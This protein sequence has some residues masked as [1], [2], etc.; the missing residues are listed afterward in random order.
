MTFGFNICIQERD[1]VNL[2]C[3]YNSLTSRFSSK[4]LQYFSENHALGRL[5]EHWIQCQRAQT[6]M[7]ECG[8]FPWFLSL[9][10]SGSFDIPN[11]SGGYLYQLWAIQEVEEMFPIN[12]DGVLSGPEHVRFLYRI[13]LRDINNIPN[14]GDPEWI[15]FGFCY[16]TKTAQKQLLAK[17]Y[18][19]LA[20]HASLNEIAT[21][22]KSDTLL[23]LMTS[24][25]ISI[26]SLV[27]EGIF[28]R[29][30]S[31]E[32]IGI[33]RLMSEVSH[34]LAGCPSCACKNTRCSFYSKNEPFLCKE[35]EADYGFLSVNTWERW[36]LL[37]FYSGLFA[38]P[39]FNPHKMQEAKRDPDSQV[40]ETYIESLAPGFRRTIWDEHLTD[41]M[42]PKLGTRLRF[43]GPHP[44][45][46][47]FIHRIP[48]SEGV[49][50]NVNIEI[51]WIRKQYERRRDEV[52]E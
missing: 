38:N 40:L 36:R 32:T 42:F 43:K 8:C 2:F 28:P 29:Q 14:V 22:W 27:S 5:I 21:A 41:G 39:N 9:Y 26:S 44:S 46:E 33:Y 37:N 31:P 45:C 6:N 18:I 35:S 25:G 4:R 13:L 15:R 49:E 3:I 23:D 20:A 17:A 11:H 30:P 1:I 10:Q 7:E 24:K 16:C 51:K 34:G 12:H 52:S 47:C 50:C 48:S 19:Q